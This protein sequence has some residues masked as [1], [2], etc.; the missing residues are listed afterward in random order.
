MCEH[1]G[2]RGVEPIAELMDEHYALLDEAHQVRAALA[3][4]DR[5]TALDRLRVLVGHLGRHV[6]REEDGVFA[7]LRDRGEYLDEVE[8]LEKEHVLLDDGIA[9]LD[10]D[11]PLLD[12]AVE[13]LFRELEEHIER[14]N[15]GVFPVSVVTL[16]ARGWDTVEQARRTYPTFL[17]GN[18]HAR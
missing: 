1:C 16:G 8:Q 13:A 17:E 2:C 18:S 4:G 6:H 7:A 15:L 3:S 11:D 9:R 14:E 5:R 12:R 10:P